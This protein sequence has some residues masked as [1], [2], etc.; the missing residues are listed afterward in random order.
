MKRF[1]DILMQSFPT[2]PHR[3]VGGSL[4]FI[5]NSALAGRSLFSFNFSFFTFNISLFTLLA[6]TGCIE[7]PLNLPVQEVK[8][9]MSIETE[10]M[11]EVWNLDVDWQTYW[12]YDWDEYDLKNWG[13]ISYPE[14]KSYEVRRYFLGAE[15]GALHTQVDSFAIYEPHFRRAYQF[16]YYDML[17]WSHI[18]N[19][20]HTQVVLFD[21]SDLN[22]VHA[23]TTYSHGMRRVATRTAS[24]SFSVLS[25]AD[26]GSTQVTALFNQPE[27]FYATIASDVHISPN[28]EDY[29]YYDEKERCW[30]K[31]LNCVLTPRVYIYLVQVIVRNNQSGRIKDVSGDNALSN[32]AAGTSVNTGHTWNM[33]AVVYFGSRMK[34]DMQ[35]EGET[36][37]VIGAKLTTF[38]LCDMPAYHKGLEPTYTGSRTDLNN[39]L[40]IDITRGNGAKQTLQIDVT[41]QVRSQSHGGVITVVIDANELPDVTP[42]DPGSGSLFVPTVDD[43]EEVIYD[44]IM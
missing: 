10:V 26:D 24:S 21:E 1:F 7:P 4:V 30:V 15:P 34:H 5:L 22:N 9:E 40:Y 8:I 35:F 20:T 41:K 16:G 32:M 37:D 44:I 14:P 43:Y 31:K 27:V 2:L 23:S 6:V 12:Y 25:S 29:D 11:A 13:D 3:R 18:D 28:K 38:G 33:P 19:E 17:L 39:D 36:V 42:D